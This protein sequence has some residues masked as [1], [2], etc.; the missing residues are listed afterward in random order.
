MFECESLRLGLHLNYCRLLTSELVNKFIGPK[1]KTY[2][3]YRDLL[4]DRSPRL[5]AACLGS[6]IEAGSKDLKL[7]HGDESAFEL[8]V[9][10]L[11]GATLKQ[12][13]DPKEVKSYFDLLAILEK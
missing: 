9:K 7:K 3:I 5:K 8:F 2:H 13:A 10:W 4:C 1:R 12:I 6:F 11:Y